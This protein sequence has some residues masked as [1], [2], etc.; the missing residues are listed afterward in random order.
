MNRRLALVG[1]AGALIAG[2]SAAA[3]QT[4]SVLYVTEIAQNWFKDGSS[5]ELTSLSKTLVHY[6]AAASAETIAKA[7]LGLNAKT[8]TG[9]FAVPTGIRVSYRDDQGQTHDLPNGGGVII[10]QEAWFELS[11]S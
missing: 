3:Q 1:A 11:G 7:R 2:R 5:T 8:P 6:V 9:T 10:A 4:S